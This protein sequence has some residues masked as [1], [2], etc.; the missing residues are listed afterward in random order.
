LDVTRW[1]AR[2]DGLIMWSSGSTGIPKAIVKTGDSFLANLRR[3]IDLVGH[4][5]DDVLVPLL[6][7]SHQ[8]GLSMVLIAWLARCSLVVAPYRRPDQALRMAEHWGGTVF[9]ATPA[10]YRTMLQLAHRRPVLRRTLADARMLC[11]GAAP[12]DPRLVAAYREETGHVLLDS[13]GS[14]EMGNVSFATLANPVACGQPV[15]G[16]RCRIVD[17]AGAEAAPGQVGEIMVATPDLMAGY[18]GAS[19]ELEPV[20]DGPWYASG[21]FGRVDSA[22]N[23]TVLG[24]KRAV[25]R[26]GYTL[27]PDII[28]RRLTDAGCSVRIVAL[29]DDRMGSQLV[30]FV[31]DERGRPPAYWRERIAGVLPAYEAPNRIVVVAEFPLNHNGK[32]DSRRMAELAVTG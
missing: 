11:S 1:R 14:T 9:D 23:L 25:H 29:P 5:A 22:G 21:D 15:A 6:P 30:A 24:R 31:E 13:Y 10:T 3:N 19:G 2:P 12:L 32:P 17:D 7:F 28:E 4:R 26:M 18:L 8:Y 20:T 27:F 16:V